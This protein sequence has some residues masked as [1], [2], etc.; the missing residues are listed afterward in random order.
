M[1]R[2]YGILHDIYWYFMSYI[3]RLSARFKCLH[4]YIGNL[5]L[6][7]DFS[8]P[9]KI[10][11]I[12]GILGDTWLFFKNKFVKRNYV[13]KNHYEFRILF[14]SFINRSTAIC[15]ASWEQTCHSNANFLFPSFL[16]HGHSEIWWERDHTCEC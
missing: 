4:L 14:H 15:L 10:T 1:K 5:E 3:I 12:L 6:L 7:N 9:Q 11:T 13:F 8:C 2:T 16:K